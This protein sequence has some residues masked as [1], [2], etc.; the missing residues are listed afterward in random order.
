ME[1]YRESNHS[2]NGWE[3]T[4]AGSNRW[5]VLAAVALLAIAVVAFG[6]G[7][8]QQSMVSQLTAQ[9]AMAN[10][11]VSQMQGQLSALTTKLNE[12]TVAQTSAQNPAPSTPP[13]ATASSEPSAETS[14]KTPGDAS[15]PDHPAKAAPT[16]RT[17]KHRAPAV[18]KKYAQLQ[19]QLAEQ[20]KQLKET[21][22]E[23]AKN[24]SDLEGNII[25]LAMTSM[26]PSQNARGTSS[27]GEARRAQLL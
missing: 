6:Y 3:A 20:Q 26:V 19:T 21:Q 23:V 8:H 11:T 18:D 24:R 7:H 14:A 13:S 2:E 9:A 15:T 22:E 1:E 4:L 27:A 17:A 5:L 12:M 25:P 10:A 16:K